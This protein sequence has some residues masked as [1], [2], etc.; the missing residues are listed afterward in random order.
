VLGVAA[1]QG[2]QHVER[3][4]VEIVLGEVAAQ[5]AVEQQREP[6]HPADH[7]HRRGIQI[8]ALLG[9][10]TEHLVDMVRHTGK[11][12]GSLSGEINHWKVA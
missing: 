6:A 5:L 2:G 8:R 3:R 4:A 12:T 9:P 11:P 1:S 10:L 7:G